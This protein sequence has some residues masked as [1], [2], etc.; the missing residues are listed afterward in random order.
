MQETIKKIHLTENL[1]LEGNMDLNEEIKRTPNRNYVG[2]YLNFTLL[3]K[4][5]EKNTNHK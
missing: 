4:S 2:I 5:L 1:I 3:F